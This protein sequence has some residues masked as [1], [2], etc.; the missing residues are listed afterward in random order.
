MKPG[1]WYVNNLPYDD[2]WPDDRYWL[3]KALATSRWVEGIFTF[4]NNGN[5]IKASLTVR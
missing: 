3:Y 1:K 4:S 5:I 2:M